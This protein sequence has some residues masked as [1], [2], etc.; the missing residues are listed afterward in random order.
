MTKRLGRGLADLIDSQSQPAATS[1]SYVMLR[2]DQIRPGRFQPRSAMSETKLEELKASIKHSG[3]IEP[4]VVRPVAHGT[5]E[6]VAGERRLRASQAL[7]IQEVPAL[8][9]TLSDKEALE[10]SI[11]ENI[12]RE[13]LNP[14][15]EAK[16]Y[17]RLLS[18][19]GY[20]QEEIASSVGKDRATIAN[21]LRVLALPDEIRQ[22]LGE[23]AIS[24]GHAKV[25]LG[26]ADPAKQVDLYRQAV[27]DACSVRQIEALA[28]AWVPAKRRRARRT[29]TD[30]QLKGLED[31][32]RRALGTKV[33]LLSRKKG[34]RIVVDYFSQEDFN[35]I[36]QL[37][38]V[39]V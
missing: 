27:K 29:A 32:L 17:E 30:P 19:F 33:S 9:K 13:E 4:I 36:L 15:E 26:V 22:G 11:V 14:L 25:L 2:T 28:G 35:R 37:F 8:I 3:V 18:E 34:G 23:G 6:V 10:F 31:E 39:S 7:G 20:T 16:G 38:G 21:L 12:Q 24:L 1:T 5:Y